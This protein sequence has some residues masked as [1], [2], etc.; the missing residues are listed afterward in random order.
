MRMQCEN[1]SLRA[2][3][4]HIIF[5]KFSYKICEKSKK[6]EIQKFTKNFERNEKF[7]K[8]SKKISKLFKKIKRFQ[9]KV[10]KM[11]KRQKFQNKF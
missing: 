8:K 10:S 9:K 11:Q 4:D 6:L 1:F 7:P 5:L 2:V 3:R